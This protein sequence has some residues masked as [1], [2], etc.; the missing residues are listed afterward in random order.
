[1]FSLRT[2]L[3]PCPVPGHRCLRRHSRSSALR[4]PWDVIFRRRRRDEF[5]ARG[6]RYPNDQEFRASGTLIRNLIEHLPAERQR[7]LVLFGTFG[8]RRSGAGGSTIPWERLTVCGSIGAILPGSRV[9]K[10]GRVSFSALRHAV[11]IS[12]E[13]YRHG[14]RPDPFLLFP[15]YSTKPLT[16]LYS[17]ILL[18]H[19]ARH[20]KRRIIVISKQTELDLVRHFSR[21]RRGKRDLFIPA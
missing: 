16:R 4:R 19:V 21:R 1:M 12:G 10:S 15:E 3:H 5:F 7:Q 20:A 6:P 2:L 8:R 9:E 11:G 17:R 18:R 14:V 13:F